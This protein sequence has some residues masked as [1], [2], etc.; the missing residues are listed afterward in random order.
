MGGKSD[1]RKEYR[2]I[3][4]G[5]NKIYSKPLLQST[6]HWSAVEERWRE[7]IKVASKD[8]QRPLGK[9]TKRRP[10]LR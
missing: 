9:K 1:Y 2:H 7:E 3:K 6:F 4:I 5:I 10:R 8:C